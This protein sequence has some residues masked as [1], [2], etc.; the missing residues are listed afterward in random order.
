MSTFFF[1]L[2]YKKNAILLLHLKFTAVGSCVNRLNG[3]MALVEYVH[4]NR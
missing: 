4:V 2:H 3:N 1:V